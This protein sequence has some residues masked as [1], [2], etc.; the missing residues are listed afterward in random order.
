MSKPDF[1]VVGDSNVPGPNAACV[2]LKLS[3]LLP[4][5]ATAHQGKFAWLA[6]LQDDPV[7]VTPDVAEVLARFREIAKGKIA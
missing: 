5:L 7:L 4:L 2:P 3:D 1:R 6:D